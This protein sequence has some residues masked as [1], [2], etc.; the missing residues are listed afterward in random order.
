MKTRAIHIPSFSVIVIFI[1][2]SLI[3][4]VLLPKLT[5]KLHPARY[6]PQLSVSFSMYGSSA[7]VVE[8]EV[9]SKLEALLGKIKGVK[10]IYSES[11]NDRGYI[12]LSLD[13]HSSIE[14]VRLE[15]SS[16]I[17]QVW[18]QLPSNTSYP[19][20]SLSRPSQ[21]SKN[22]D[23]FLAY[24][25][26]APIQSSL[27]QQWI[28]KEIRPRLSS[29]DGIRKI[30]ISEGRRMEWSLEYDENKI[31]TIGITSRDIQS[32]IYEYNRTTSLGLAWIRNEQDNSEKY[33]RITFATNTS[34]KQDNRFHPEYIYVSNS[35][36]KRFRLDQITTVSY[37][38]EKPTSYNRINGLDYITI[39]IIAEEQANQIE[40]GNR[41]KQLISNIQQNLPSGYNIYKNYDATTQIKDELNNIYIRTFFTILILLIFVFITTLNTRYLIMI[42]LSLFFNIAI[43][44]VLY[45]FLKLE[46]QLYSL[47]GITISLSLIIDNTIIMAD[48]YKRNRNRKVFMAILAATLTTIGAL[49]MIFFLDEET[50]FNLQDFSIII[51]INLTVSLFIAL[52]LVPA[53]SEKL[54][55][56]NHKPTLFFKNHIKLHKK[57]VLLFNRLY[58][59]QIRISLRFRTILFLI[60]ILVFGL[61]TFMLPDHIE[62]DGWAA[63]QYN[64]IFSSRNFKEDYRP[65]IDKLLGGY[66]RLFAQKVSNGEYYTQEDKIQLDISAKFPKKMD[67]SHT[68]FTIY[69][70]ENHISKYKNKIKRFTTIIPNSQA[71][72]IQIQF[73]D[74]VK[75][76]FFPIQLKFELISIARHLGGCSWSISGI[77]NNM[78]SNEIFEKNGDLRIS[79]SGYNYDDL[80]Q[81]ALRLKDT[82]LLKYRR[83]PE[84]V[85]NS[86]LSFRKEDNEIFSFNFNH[87]KM[88]K[89]QIS[90]RE[91]YNIIS[92]NL[93]KDL[94]C[95]VVQNKNKT[96]NIKISSVQSRTLDR[97][98][99][100]NMSF[101]LKNK[102][103]KLSE[104]TTL[105]KQQNPQNIVKENQQYKLFLQYNFLGPEYQG[106]RI[107]H[108]ELQK[109]KET[110]PLGYTAEDANQRY[111]FLEKN[112]P[113]LLL[114]IIILILFFMTS[115]LFNSLTQPIAILFIIPISYIGIF[116]TFYHFNLKFDQ[117]GFASF[118]LLCGTTVNAS[119]YIVNE[120]NRLIK[121]FPHK[122]KLNLYVKAWN[123]KIIPIL[124]TILSTLLGFLPFIIGLEKENFWFPLAA[125]TTGGLLM[126][127]IGIYFFLPLLLFG[128]KQ[129][130]TT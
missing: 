120:Y 62:K 55:L 80:L 14:K 48:H 41:V 35:E 46:I 22:S 56:Y 108:K 116:I 7:R 58:D 26:S 25:I 36:G 107:L 5:V 75:R 79:L 125:G 109:F 42:I 130:R 122:D 60:V 27:I 121:K 33:A 8:V 112:N 32:A 17:R 110:L 115:I 91:F 47:A 95:G 31:S 19:S 102:N 70:M 76:T 68:N 61:P 124:L 92:S 126:S 50:R 104:F 15:A 45:Y 3:G 82:L 1:A 12:N 83:I 9:T 127:L 29:I 78:F 43:A 87:E 105:T 54:L 28:E 20:I 11:S 6:T 74:S 64:K 114:G 39:S 77:D 101:S 66:L 34:P 81:H 129:K 85:I 24:D 4:M 128:K 21:G 117:G 53:L 88:E 84:V 90:S 23:V 72:Y 89:Y 103:Y 100:E 96:E 71:A 118:I 59:N 49:S 86:R 69:Q 111:H 40:V 51:I 2:I 93:A 16:I 99:I 44:F 73:P 65:I 30:Q 57:F 94:Q 52:F 113:Y 38:E 97:W 18:Q 13:K 63:H 106:Q 123:H 10:S 119:I 37:Q 98:N 67:I